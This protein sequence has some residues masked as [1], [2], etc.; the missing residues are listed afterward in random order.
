MTEELSLPGLVR[1]KADLAPDSVF[2]RTVAGRT[3]TYQQADLGSRRL[4]TYLR[5]VGIHRGDRV[6]TMFPTDVEGVLTWMALGWLGAWEVPV[7]TAYVGA[8]LAHVAADSSASTAVVDARFAERLIA[9]LDHTP[10]LETLVVF[11]DFTVPAGCRVR[12]LV[13]PDTESS[14]PWQGPTPYG[15]DVSCVMYT[16][17]TTGPSKGVVVPW[18]QLHATATGVF[19]KGA[20]TERDRYYCPFPLC[21]VS[22][23][24][25][26]TGMAAAGGSAV[27]R[28]GFS[29]SAFWPEI[30]AEGCTVTML[31]GAVANFLYRQDPRPDDDA[32]PLE[33]VMMVPIIPEVA[34]FRSRFGVDVVS[35]FSM[36]EVSCPLQTGWVTTPEV[37]CGWVR[38]GY[39]VRVVDELDHP[40]PD[41]E[42]GELVVRASEPWVLMNGYWGRPEDTVR[43][44]RNQWFHTG[45]AFLRRPDGTFHFADRLKDSIRRRGENISSFEVESAANQYPGVLETAA[46]AVPSEWGEDEIK[47]VFVVKPGASVDPEALLLHLASTLPHFMVPR[48]FERVDELP[49][50][51]TQKVQKHILRA[52]GITSKT[53]DREAAGISVTR[54]GVRR[55]PYD[56]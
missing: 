36:T 20:L 29:T 53:W 48:Y 52:T 32:H 47:L 9:V 54:N 25:I 19:P 50:T 2:L 6:L 21:H 12:V 13:N 33:K 18:A 42:I 30:D 5:S 22:G 7:N 35:I 1:A 14:E 31:L 56:S 10:Q 39:D 43:A 49:R 27:L 3:L 15:S 41:G 24:H 51:E 4:A 8:M 28:D 38:P 45:D 11:G 17:G 37:G 26:V 23:K 46:V 55:Q 16:S 34:D 40:L 44:W